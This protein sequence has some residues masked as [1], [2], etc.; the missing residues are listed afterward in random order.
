MVLLS[1]C[2]SVA[3][4]LLCKAVPEVV[5]DNGPAGQQN[6]VQVIPTLTTTRPNTCRLQCPHSSSMTGMSY[7]W[8]LNP[9]IMASF[10]T[11]N[12]ITKRIPWRNGRQNQ[13]AIVCLHTVG[14]INTN[15][16]IYKWF[17]ELVP[18]KL[19]QTR[20]WPSTSWYWLICFR[21]GICGRAVIDRVGK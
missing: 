17:A 16:R 9:H 19:V 1:V 11:I 13:L 10:M 14:L 8:A 21:A 3:R 18:G 12:K 2:G 4:V 7:K 15:P 20:R 5:R 6:L